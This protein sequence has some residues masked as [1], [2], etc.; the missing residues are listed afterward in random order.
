MED[1][2]AYMRALYG[3]VRS[4]GYAYIAAAINAAHVDHI[5]LYRSPD[6]VAAEIKEAG[7]AILKRHSEMAYA[8]KP[9]EVTPCHAGFLCRRY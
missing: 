1:P 7:F 3:M 6:E 4:G 2:V 9:R 5:Y 8:G